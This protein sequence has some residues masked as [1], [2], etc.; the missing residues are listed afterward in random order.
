MATSLKF[1]DDLLKALS[2]LYEIK[3]LLKPLQDEEKSIKERIKKWM[4]LNALK[5]HKTKDTDNHVWSIL[6]TGQTRK[7]IV[8]WKLLESILNKEGISGVVK[9]NVI[10]SY[11]ITCPELGLE[12]ED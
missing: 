4:D 11:R 8:D 1:E 6:K 7:S 5:S 3:S 2:K 10:E 12:K 9:E